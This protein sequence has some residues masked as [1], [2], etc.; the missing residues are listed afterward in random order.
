MNKKT[1]SGNKWFVT[2]MLRNG[3]KIKGVVETGSDIN[4]PLLAYET[5]MHEEGSRVVVHTYN[6]HG[7]GITFVHRFEVVAIRIATYEE[8]EIDAYE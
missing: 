3:E 6:N 8:D 2:L 1:E 7:W 5:I 4:T